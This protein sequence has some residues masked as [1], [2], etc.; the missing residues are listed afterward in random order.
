MERGPLSQG[1]LQAEEAQAAQLVRAVLETE[2]PE[3][4]PLQAEASP[5]EP[6]HI[7]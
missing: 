3:E 5:E 7:Q 6:Q 1:R 4:G 2:L